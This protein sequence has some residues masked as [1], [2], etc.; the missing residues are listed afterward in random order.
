MYYN[1][2]WR[3]LPHLYFNDGIYFI[4]S[5]LAGTIPLDKLRS[6]SIAGKYKNEMSF[7]DFKD[8]FF[9]YDSFLD[10]NTENKQILSDAK[11][12]NILAECIK[13]PDG[14]DYK[15][16]CYTI[17]PNHFHFAFELL[18]NNK[19]ISKIM[20]SIKGN[21]SR[22]INKYLNTDGRLW[23]DESYDRWVR[24]DK[25]LYFVIKYILLNPV[26]AGLVKNWYEWKNTYCHP[27]YIIL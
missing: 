22:K 12:S 4:T 19:G 20:Q 16:I 3:N 2:K 5:R 10:V 25:E 23:Q 26:K 9:A 15:L 1:L 24:D 21:S 11:V 7:E 14:K 8:H 13:F 27:D 6:L 18:A 17:M